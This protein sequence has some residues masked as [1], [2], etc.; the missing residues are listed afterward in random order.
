MLMNMIPGGQTTVSFPGRFLAHSASALALMAVVAGGEIQAQD[1]PAAV[2]RDNPLAYYR[3]NDSLVRSAVNVNSGSLGTAGNATNINAQPFPGGLAGD[4][5]LSQFYNSTAWAEIPWNAALNPTNTQPFTM[6]AWLYPASDQISGGQAAIMN[7][8]SYSGVD[9]QG[10]VIFQRSPNDTYA[11][12]PGNEGIG[13]NFR[14]Y[15]GSGSSSGLDVVSQVPFEIGTWT[16]L[17]VVYDPVEVTNATLTMYINGVAANTNIW[18]GEGPGYVANTDDHP[19]DEA[20]NGPASLALGSY[21]NTAPGS[22]PYFGAVDE[23][24]FYGTKLTPEQIQAHYQNG[25]N[26]ARAVAYPT[27]IQADN[28]VAYLRLDE[29]S[30]GPPVTLN[31]GNSRAA[32]VATPTVEVVR[33]VPSAVTDAAGDTAYGFHQRNGNSVTTIPW[34]AENNPDASVPF[35]FEAW[36]RPTSGRQS[37]GASPI[38]NRY[39]G[40]A[41]RTGWVI[42]QRAPNEEEAG[43]DGVGWNF[44][45][46]TG[47][48]TGGQDVVTG[49]PFNLGEWQQVVV[50][51]TPTTDN[52]DG[53]WT[54]TLASYVNGV[55]AAV[56]E[57]VIYKAN[58][59]PPE[60]DLPP[61]DLAV[62]AYN[63]A[64]GLGSNPFEG[65]IDEVAIYNNYL[66]T[67]EQILA[68]YEAGTNAHP[69]TP[70]ATQVLMA[71][72]DGAGTQRSMPATY[73]R[74]SDPARY[75]AAN[76]GTLGHLAAGSLVVT[77]NDVAGPQPPAF[78]GFTD[79]NAAVPLDGTKGW[80][81]LNNP[82]ALNLAGQVTMEAWLKPGA[83]QGA[84]ANIVAHGTNGVG[85]EVYLRIDALGNYAV[86][87]SDGTTGQ[88]AVF[89]VPAGDLG[90]A[91]WIHL[92]GTYDGTAWHLYRNGLPVATTSAATGAVAVNDANWAIGSTGSGWENYFTGTVDEVAIYGK[93]LSAD[94]VLAHYNAGVSGDQ[95][96][97]LSIGLSGGAVT[98]TWA[99]GTL[100]AADILG[101]TYGDV[102]GAQSPYLPPLTSNMKF[103]RLRQ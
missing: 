39:V 54:G 13:W 55:A 68:H 5:N 88:G 47:T 2:L 63:A 17:V 25:T 11:N 19:V 93:A 61:A 29:L 51:W 64:S 58:T 16:H 71:A 35:T 84:I 56:N 8:Y 21:N 103:Y 27:L 26:A 37:P 85:A 3:L 102:S 76:H 62:G 86:G 50:T 46:F 74:L 79:T 49:V 53:S 30:D 10:W 96:L 98:L 32:G 38:N 67:A 48:G 6:E 43:G 99:A 7:R 42:F 91:S 44:R 101:G 34:I 57:S 14:M 70:Y 82:S 59:N 77:T 4:G 41:N 87:S 75:P 92:V 100:Q 72:Y 45:M 20:P 65:D 73:L 24:A 28:P 31:L 12:A 60:D 23:F 94:Q 78:A 97:A 1:Y 52:G 18:A 69:A 15:R 95:S 40:S 81:N 89:P 22:N 90:S 36:F 83:V 80:V 33:P 66:L 9:R